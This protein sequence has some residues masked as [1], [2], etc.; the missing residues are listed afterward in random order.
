MAYM[1]M[2]ISDQAV[3]EKCRDLEFLCRDIYSYFADLYDGNDE[4]V[5]LWRKTSMEEQNHADQF[6]LALKLNKGLAC[7]VTV[8]PD[9]LE[10]IHTQ[11]R[12]VLEKVKT[13]PPTLLDALYSSIKMEKYLSDF[14]LECVVEFEDSS[15]KKLFKAMMAS[16]QEHIAS[17]QAAYDKLKDT[18]DRTLKG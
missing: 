3:L 7:M 5:R 6:T 16:D 14:H 4:A 2:N 8:K 15:Y 18:H 12:A 1:P 13:T 9:T 10:S 17:L 11:M